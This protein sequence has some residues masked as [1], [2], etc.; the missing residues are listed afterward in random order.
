[1]TATRAAWL[2]GA[3]ALVGI[4]GTLLLVPRKAPLP[5]V[6]TPP[7]PAMRDV[8]ASPSSGKAAPA[9]SAGAQEEPARS[10]VGR[11]TRRHALEQAGADAVEQDA[12]TFF[13]QLARIDE[14]G[15]REA[16]LR[17][18]FEHAAQL[19]VDAALALARGLERRADRETALIALLRTWS[20]ATE[21]EVATQ[22]DKTA[23]PAGWLGQ[24]LLYR[25][26]VP[27]AQ[28]AGLANDF[29]AGSQ[30]ASL[31]GEA[32]SVLAGSDPAAAVRLGESLS[33]DDQTTFLRGFAVGW[34]Q[35]NHAAAWAWAAQVPDAAMR[36]QLQASIVEVEAVK[37]LPAAIEHYRML[38]ES[39]ARAGAAAQIA[40]QWAATDTVAAQRWID[41]LASPEERTEAMRGFQTS[42]P[43]G[44]GVALQVDADGVASVN[45]LMPGSSAM[46]SGALQ[47]GDRIV[48]ISDA[49]GQWV[50][51]RELRLEELVKLI[52]GKPGT[53]VSLR[54]LGSSA[55]NDAQPRI[56]NL[57]RQQ[58]VHRP[59]A[60]RSP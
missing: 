18:A 2:C 19:G 23:T 57:P 27:P 49:S 55:P 41:T 47:P 14:K 38:P 15:A 20:G 9:D 34:A 35:T 50:D 4:T 36:T 21:A 45:T 52:R 10:A 1:M 60:S 37:N 59:E 53:T 11:F 7:A 54:V 24:F 56:V 31:L 42:A 5:P 39:D 16:F 13:D 43:V 44:I 6:V 26:S 46:R 48:G 3:S 40:S 51:A 8:E 33:G 30:R 25:R 12:A 58:I 32:A 28:V 17:G 22:L 29:L